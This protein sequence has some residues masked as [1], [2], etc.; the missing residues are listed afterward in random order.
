MILLTYI[1]SHSLLVLLSTLELQRREQWIDT[2]SFIQL[3]FTQ[4][5]YSY[6]M[7]N[8]VYQGISG[9][10]LLQES[11]GRRKTSII[12]QCPVF[13]YFL[14]WSLKQLSKLC[15]SETEFHSAGF[16]FPADATILFCDAT[17]LILTLLFSQ[18][19]FSSCFSCLPKP[20]AWI[21]PCPSFSL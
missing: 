21:S 1:L 19:S 12:F 8:S 4:V 3:A 9:I 20:L 14:N 11:R 18:D 7:E 5:N 15:S 17:I 6:Q 13:V 16:A 2:K 10:Q